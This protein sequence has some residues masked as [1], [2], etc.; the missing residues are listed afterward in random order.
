MARSS[1]IAIDAAVAHALLCH[2]SPIDGHGMPGDKRGSIRTE[3]DHRFRDFFWCADPSHGFT[4][5]DACPPFGIAQASCRHRRVDHAW[6][7]TIDPNPLLRILQ[8]RCFGQS[9]HPMLTRHIGGKPSGTDQPC[10]RSCIDNGPAALVQHLG[11]FIF[12]AE[13]DACQVDRDHLM[14]RVF[15]ILCR[16]RASS[17]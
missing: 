14:P 15:G 2:I 6:T 12:H 17:S 16:E 5:N 8:R 4:G 13:P 9:H 1:P 10:H 3:P 11:D 7:D